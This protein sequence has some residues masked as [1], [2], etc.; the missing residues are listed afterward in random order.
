MSS[1]LPCP[2]VG[3]KSVRIF[4]QKNKRG[5]LPC[6]KWFAGLPPR[7]RAPLAELQ[8]AAA[9]VVA[10]D[11]FHRGNLS[12]LEGASLAVDLPSRT[13]VFAI[14]PSGVVAGAGQITVAYAQALQSSNPVS[15]KLNLEW[16]N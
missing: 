6:L 16:G 7:P 5:P 10:G 3:E 1:I 9:L 8:G 4:Q 15:S 2:F 13:S 11:G 14:E 12:L